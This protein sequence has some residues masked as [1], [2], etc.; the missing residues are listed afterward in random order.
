[1][2]YK[3]AEE[4]VS[5]IYVQYTREEFDIS[6]HRRLQILFKTSD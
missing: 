2:N 4:N 6:K 3:I 1:M 5:F